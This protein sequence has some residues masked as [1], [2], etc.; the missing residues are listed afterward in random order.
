MATKAKDRP[1]LTM[2]T[3]QNAAA[4]QREQKA[5]MEE[6]R[7]YCEQSL[8][9][10]RTERY[11]WWLHWAEI[12]QY[13]LPRRYIW[14]VT[15][16]RQTR[17]SPINQH[18][19]DSTG[20][21][22]ART[23]ANGMMSG[24]V[25]P[26]APWFRLT[27]P[28]MRVEEGTPIKT[29]LA[30][31]ESRMLR[32]FAE[33]NYYQSKAQQLMDLTVF[34]T[35]PMIIYSDFHNVINCYLPA[36]GEYFVANSNR[37]TVDRLYREFVMTARQ[38]VQEFGL[39]AVSESVR[40]SWKTPG[41]LTREVVIAHAIEPNDQDDIATPFIGKSP[42][43]EVYWERD[44]GGGN[45]LRI[46]RFN[47]QPFSCPRWDLVG[48]DPYGRSPAMDALGDIKQL[49]IETKRKGQAIDKMVN[50]PMIA[51]P[52]LKNQPASMLPGGI[53]YV[54]MTA[55]VG[56]KPV[57]EVKPEIAEM[58][59]DIKEVQARIQK[60]FFNDL[61]QMI[62]NLDTVRSA[63]E[64]IERRQE[65]L[66]QLGPV[67][68]RF[69][70]E[71]LQHDISRTYGIMQELRLLPPIPPEMQGQTI[72]VQYTSMLAEMQ[73][74]TVTTAIERLFAFAGNLAGIDP[75]VMDNLDADEALDEY[76]E[77]LRAPPKVI[78]DRKVVIQM[79]AAKE[80]AM[81]Q[82]QQQQQ[83]AGALQTGMAAAQG[84]KTLSETDVGGGQN[85]LQMMVGGGR[86]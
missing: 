30:E 77:S 31:V 51:D 52:S 44:G 81:Q 35:A 78:R 85:A 54:P 33:G 21:I 28:D 16:N 65:K 83:M 32:I 73:R 56:M 57:Y 25:S 48:N 74:A 69:Q 63:T 27:L 6:L 46:K 37:F 66:V 45:I 5:Q 11:S 40:A 12:A 71:S 14:L 34:G 43:R 20:T 26:S 47:D 7:Q 53:T 84:A 38:V 3:P 68:E 9:S 15:P 61:F 55:G 82:A 58:M 13:I 79:R 29:W 1:K 50:P 67:L 19:I 22:A 10:L 8:Q 49:Q 41:S 72:Q 70:A 86:R 2:V 62:S 23:C 36:A 64:I 80:K 59:A 18:I 75:H 42:W 4:I 24:M 60:V 76:A 17:G 39:S